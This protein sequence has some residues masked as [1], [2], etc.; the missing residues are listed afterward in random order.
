MRGGISTV[1]R[2]KRAFANNP[3]MKNY[4]SSK[5][6][7]YIMYFDVTNLYGKAM[8]EKLPIDSFEFLSLETIS[9]LS[10]GNEIDINKIKH[11]LTEYNLNPNQDISFIFEVDL[12]YPMSLKDE[13]CELPLAP[14]HFEGKLTPNLF[15][16]Y[17][18]VTRIENLIYYVEK[19]LIIS[20][21]HKILKFRQKAWLKD[22]IEFN[23]E[24]RKLTKDEN[25]RN[26]YKLMNNSV[27]GKTMENILGRPNLTLFNRVN[28]KL[29]KYTRS[30]D[31][32]NEFILTDDLV[33][34]AMKKKTVEYNKP[35]YVGFSILEI[36]K[37][38]MY[39]KL[40][41]LLKA[42]YGDQFCLL[43]M[44]TDSKFKFLT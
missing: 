22:Y 5:P 11:L 38:I 21:I 10:C 31:F 8:T 3:Y 28:P 43:Y 12:I 35:I 6:T 1:S 41:G 44:D 32:I 14:E 20:K 17:N 19:G 24:M 26:F 42:R 9:N 15:N 4:D 25:Q 18:Y 40:Y 36:S 29:L 23:T 2:K 27:F 30:E 37:K 16:K 13:H 39:E 7:S 34:V 33:V